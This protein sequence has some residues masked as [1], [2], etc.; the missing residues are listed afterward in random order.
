MYAIF[1]HRKSIPEGKLKSLNDIPLEDYRSTAE[2]VSLLRIAD[3]LDFGFASGSPDKIEK[4]EMARTP[5]GV[6]C[7]VFPR[8]GMNVTELVAKSYEKR[9][10]FETIFGKLTFWLPGE[11][12]SWVPWHP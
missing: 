2:L 9:E 8:L 12:G 10:V 5:K 11:Q 7:R 1:Y 4:V 3:G 6:E